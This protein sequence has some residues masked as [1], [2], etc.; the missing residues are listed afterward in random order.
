MQSDTSRPVWSA[1]LPILVGFFALIVLVGGLG[2]WSVQTQL[3]GAVISTGVIEVQSNRQVVQHPEGGVVGEILVRDGD[4]VEAG[5]ILVRFD[6][7]FSVSEL[8]IV[9]A[10][11]FELLARK[12][13]L[14]AERDGASDLTIDGDLAE[15]ALNDPLVQSLIEGQSRLFAS[16]KDSLAKRT[17][18]LSEQIKQTMSQIVGTQAQLT[19][20]EQ[21]DALIQDELTDQQNLLERGLTQ[22]SRVTALMREKARLDGDTGRLEAESARLK[23][24]IA[25]TEIEILRLSTSRQEE[26]ITTLRDLQFREIELAERRVALQEQMAR[27]D[28]RAPVTGVVYGSTVFALQSVVQP[29]EPMMF[30]VPQD[31]PLLIAAQ[32]DAIHVDQLYIGQ[33]TTLRFPAFNQ[34]QT[35]EL[36]GHVKTISA[37]VFRDDVTGLSYYR[38]EILLNDGQTDRFEGQTL[39]PGMPVE[40]LIKTDERTPLSYLTKPLT[41]YFTKAFREG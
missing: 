31:T 10:Q 33:P 13:R 19:A 34:R 37:D 15:M 1:K 28:I 18:Q 26:A 16:R 32:V 22:A 36:D 7:T 11:L 40:T 23:A 41:D 6:D 21:Q 27:L 12:A 35:P 38:A 25:A 20:L 14:E 4:A 30:V 3:A 9:E 5:Q 24:Q 2:A 17:E 29:A 39:L 8:A